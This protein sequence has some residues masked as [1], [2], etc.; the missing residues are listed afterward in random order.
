MMNKH[1]KFIKE[2]TTLEQLSI[3][4]NCMNNHRHPRSFCLSFQNYTYFVFLL[5]QRIWSD[6]PIEISDFE[7]IS[8]ASLIYITNMLEKKFKITV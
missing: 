6:L 3:R 5:F 7:E 8:M 1:L 2:D 4:E